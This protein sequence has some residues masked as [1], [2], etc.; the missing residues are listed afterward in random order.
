MSFDPSQT[1]AQCRRTS[2]VIAKH[3]LK[4]HLVERFKL[5]KIHA[6]PRSWKRFVGLYLDP[7]NRVWL[8][9]ERWFKNELE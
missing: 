3:G 6:L 9:E 5:V 4:A 1:N 2:S 8:A 7:P